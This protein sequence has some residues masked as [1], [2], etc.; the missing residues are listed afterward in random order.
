MQTHWK[1]VLI[2]S[3]SLDTV[4]SHVYLWIWA[5]LCSP[6]LQ[7]QFSHC[8]QVC[9]HCRFA[10][11]N[12]PILGCYVSVKKWTALGLVKILYGNGSHTSHF[13]K[14]WC[15]P[16]LFSFQIESKFAKSK[17]ILQYSPC[18]PYT[19]YLFFIIILMAFLNGPMLNLWILILCKP[20]KNIWLIVNFPTR[21][22]QRL[23]R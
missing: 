3:S 19:A 2:R 9:S 17:N 15:I 16:F 1:Y 10:I 11:C 20:S 13:C 12:V 5:M 21:P 4:F 14:K 18:L 23:F 6:V 8:D 22:F 7:L